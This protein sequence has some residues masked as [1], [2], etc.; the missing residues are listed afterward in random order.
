MT[1]T[2]TCLACSHWSLRDAPAVA[3]H[4][5]GVCGQDKAPGNTSSG[6][7]PRVCIRFAPL[8]PVEVA[9]RKEWMEK[10]SKK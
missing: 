5:F 2:V 8:P 4:G 6:D 3:A 10:R 9:K 1:T 7:F